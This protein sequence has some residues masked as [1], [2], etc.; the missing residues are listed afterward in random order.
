MGGWFLTPD[1]RDGRAAGSD[2][3]YLV[4]TGREAKGF[5]GGDFWIEREGSSASNVG[6]WLDEDARR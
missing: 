6:D 3:G 1:K 4:A 2:V 5:G